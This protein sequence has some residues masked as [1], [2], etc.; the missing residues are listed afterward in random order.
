LFLRD[1]ESQTVFNFPINIIIWFLYWP[2]EN[3]GRVGTEL[4]TGPELSLKWYQH[5]RYSPTGIHKKVVWQHQ[6]I[7]VDIKWQ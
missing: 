7:S 4:S 3:G 2:K 5:L 6:Y 1:L